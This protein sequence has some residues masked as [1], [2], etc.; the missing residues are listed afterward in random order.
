MHGILGEESPGT[1]N[2]GFKVLQNDKTAGED[3]NYYINKDN[4]F[5]LETAN[6]TEWKDGYGEG[7]IYNDSVFYDVE[8]VWFYHG[9]KN[10]W[11][12]S[13]NEVKTHCYV[14]SDYTDA[15]FNS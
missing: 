6:N 7:N 5:V 1:I 4:V 3:R 12:N 15:E 13:K 11:S 9:I 2:I 10:I 14:I 8:T